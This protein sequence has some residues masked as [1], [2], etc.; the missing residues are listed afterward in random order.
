MKASTPIS[1]N[2]YKMINIRLLLSPKY[3]NTWSLFLPVHL[4]LWFINHKP[5]HCGLLLDT[6]MNISVYTEEVSK[7]FIH[8]HIVQIYVLYD[9]NCSPCAD[10]SR[11]K[12]WVNYWLN[13]ERHYGYF[14]SEEIQIPI[15]IKHSRYKNRILWMFPK[16]VD[17]VHSRLYVIVR[18][19]PEGIYYIKIC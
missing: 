18:D 5:P 4:K 11:K 7:I 6:N 10:S 14:H 16:S 2:Y 12:S 3:K 13:W 1:Q 8:M 9:K 15:S 19:G 17:M